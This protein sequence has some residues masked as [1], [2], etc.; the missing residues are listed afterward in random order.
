MSMRQTENRCPRFIKFREYAMAGGILTYG[1][2]LPDA[3]RQSG[4]YAGRIL[5][6]EKPAEMPIMQSSK[7][8]FVSQFQNSKVT[9][10]RNSGGTVFSFA[11]E[12]IE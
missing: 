3:Y 12:V 1:I 6:G 10:A 7:F 5:K 8:E 4:S 11:D 9:R 2:N